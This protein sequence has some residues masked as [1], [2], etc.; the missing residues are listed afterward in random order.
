MLSDIK[1]ALSALEA[2]RYRPVP[3]YK[4]ASNVITASAPTWLAWAVGEIERMETAYRSA[5]AGRC[6]E[7]EKL[8]ARCEVLERALPI[9]QEL[10][11]RR[12]GREPKSLQRLLGEFVAAGGMSLLAAAGGQEVAN[13]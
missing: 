13:G 8:V 4:A 11:D 12:E 6:A 9:V 3:E 5:I 2:S 10:L 1:A 7:I